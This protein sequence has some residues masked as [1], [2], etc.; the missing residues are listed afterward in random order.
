MRRLR[1]GSARLGALSRGIPGAPQPSGELRAY[2]DLYANIRPARAHPA[3]PAVS[4][5]M[6][7]VIVRENTEGFYH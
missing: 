4:P 1:A 5:R 7:L 2:F 3:V 6:D